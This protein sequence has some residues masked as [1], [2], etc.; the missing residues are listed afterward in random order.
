MVRKN[1][2]ASQE[3]NCICIRKFLISENADKRAVVIIMMHEGEVNENIT[4]LTNGASKDVNPFFG[5]TKNPAD[6]RGSRNHFDAFAYTDS[7][8]MFAF[9]SAA[10]LFSAACSSGVNLI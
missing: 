4:I 10:D 2:F 7:F 5:K 1:A 6:R 8:A 9:T 3:K